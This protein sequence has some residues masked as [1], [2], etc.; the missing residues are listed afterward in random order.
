MESIRPN[1]SD[2]IPLRAPAPPMG[3]IIIRLAGLL[4]VGIVVMAVIWGR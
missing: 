1:K 3:T 4:A 2:P